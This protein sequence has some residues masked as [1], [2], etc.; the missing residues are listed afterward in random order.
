MPSQNQPK[1]SE[2]QQ[3]KAA[4]MQT[5]WEPTEDAQGRVRTD[6]PHAPEEAQAIDQANRETYLAA[7]AR[8]YQT[9]AA[10][11]R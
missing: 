1:P 9:K 4:V 8:R 6:R 7:R 11:R 3:A 10:R 5:V 2:A